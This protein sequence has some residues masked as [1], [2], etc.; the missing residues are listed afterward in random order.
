MISTRRETN[1]T[2]P[3]DASRIARQIASALARGELSAVATWL[4]DWDSVVPL[5]HD[6]D[7]GSGLPLRVGVAIARAVLVAARPGVSPRSRIRPSSSAPL[8]YCQE[9]FWRELGDLVARI[10]EVRNVES[11]EVRK[12]Q[13]ILSKYF[14]A[15]LLTG[16]Q[17]ESVEA[18]EKTQDDSQRDAMEIRYGVDE[19]RSFGRVTLRMR[20]R[21]ELIRK[22]SLVNPNSVA[23]WIAALTF[24]QEMAAVAEEVAYHSPDSWVMRCMQQEAQAAKSSSV[25]DHFHQPSRMELR[26]A[27]LLGSINPM[28][29][30]AATSQNLTP[31]DQRILAAA[32]DWVH[33]AK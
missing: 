8:S 29:I 12:A 19:L 24:V 18:A 25:R 13:R 9:E 33:P 32:M 31:G 22:E 6:T 2:S 21:L 17:C 11:V 5:P 14:V 27:A 16:S 7:D 30:A 1:S 20:L 26:T 10:A 23:P 15:A 3:I 28:G 4:K